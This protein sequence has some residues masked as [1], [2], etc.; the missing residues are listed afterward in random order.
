[1]LGDLSFRSLDRVRLEPLAAY[2]DP[3]NMGK[4]TI[5]LHTLRTQKNGSNGEKRSHVRN[6]HNTKLCNVRLTMEIY[7]RF[8]R[9]VGWN[10]ATQNPV[11][12]NTSLPMTSNS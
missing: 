3:D 2:N 9:L 4:V 7:A 10:Y 1:M 11:L 6:E 12:S 8:I 5:T